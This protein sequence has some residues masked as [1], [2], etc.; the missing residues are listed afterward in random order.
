MS[1]RLT[2]RISILILSFLLAS[3]IIG[4]ADKDPARM[5]YLMVEKPPLRI[6]YIG[7]QNYMKPEVAYNLLGQVSKSK[8]EKYKF[9]N[10]MV[11]HVKASSHQSDTESD[12]D[13]SSRSLS[14]NK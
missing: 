7:K 12:S 11:V 4:C 10:T 6:I 14:V 2:R 3:L 13:V 1:K 9:N 5:G 8:Y